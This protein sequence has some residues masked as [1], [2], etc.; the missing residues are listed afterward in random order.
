MSLELSEN[1]KTPVKNRGFFAT[2]TK[3]AVLSKP[4]LSYKSSE[5]QIYNKKMK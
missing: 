1:K 2:L 4:T 3:Q 5:T